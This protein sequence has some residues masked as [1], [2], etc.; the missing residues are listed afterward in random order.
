MATASSRTSR[1][2]RT[3]RTA[4]PAA[5]LTCWVWLES[6]ECVDAAT[7]AEG[8]AL[9]QRYNPRETVQ[10]KDVVAL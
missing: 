2:S 6:G 10:A 9:L 7:H 4:R 8:V 1:T 5:H 3:T